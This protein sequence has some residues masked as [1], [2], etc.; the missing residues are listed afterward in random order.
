MRNKETA[1]E[2][3]RGR[4]HNTPAQSKDGRWYCIKCRAMRFKVIQK[5]RS[6]RGDTGPGLG[7]NYEED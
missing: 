4:K 5:M 6:E 7:E 3:K 2:I 1:C